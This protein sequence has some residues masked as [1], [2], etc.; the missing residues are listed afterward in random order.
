MI[1]L[2]LNYLNSLDLEKNY[3]I[4][5]NIQEY[6]KEHKGLTGAGTIDIIRN[7][8]RLI[9]PDKCYLE[10]GIYQGTNIAGVA[11]YTSCDC[12]G[13]DNF[14][15]VFAEDKLFEKT[16]EE[17]VQDKID[18]FELKNLKYFKQDYK[19]FLLNR[20]DI[21]GKKV[22]IYFYDGPHQFQDQIDGIMLA[23]DLLADQALIFIDDCAA[24][25]VQKSVEILVNDYGF[26]FV[27]LLTYYS[28]GRD[29]FGQSQCV[30]LYDKEKIK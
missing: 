19:Q 6:I 4:P 15:E 7:C 16:T 24:P 1:K 28:D 5:K 9:D 8:A 30:L 12:Y 18:K 20:K 3:T 2:M 23:K 11:Q 13:V 22:E 26:K 14:S 25:N 27:K 10:V 29:F 17:L 21:H